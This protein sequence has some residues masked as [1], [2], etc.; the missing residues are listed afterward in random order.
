MTEYLKL[1]Y[2][3]IAYIVIVPFC[4]KSLRVNAIVTK[5]ISYFFI[6]ILHIFIFEYENNVSIWVIY[7]FYSF[8][9]CIYIFIYG[10]LETSISVK[11]L[12][13]LTKK[14]AV[15][16]NNLTNKIVLKSFYIRINNLIKK[17]MI[18]KKKKK[19]YFNSIRY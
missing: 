2:L 9:V 10:A 8:F 14:R 13:Y 6:F 11:I 7:C 19:I 12:N 15:N 18:I 5:L 16:I 3:I 4:V 1:F 17:K